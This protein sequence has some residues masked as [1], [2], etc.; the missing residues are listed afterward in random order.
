MR[1]FAL[2]VLN[3]VV[4]SSDKESRSSQ[5]SLWK[6]SNSFPH[7]FHGKQDQAVFVY[8]TCHVTRFGEIRL[9]LS[10]SKSLSCA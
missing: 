3:L 9:R 6:A 4:T 10:R 1:N 2:L 5:G 8:S 7:S